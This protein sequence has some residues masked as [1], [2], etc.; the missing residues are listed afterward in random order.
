LAEPEDTTPIAAP[1]TKDP[2][3]LFPDLQTATET[4]AVTEADPLT[5]QVSTAP[6][7]S[8]GI[9]TEGPVTIATIIIDADAP[10]T[11]IACVIPTVVGYSIG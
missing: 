1:L 5:A 6:V 7:I 8:E 4:E 3:G 2:E 10:I 11:I 9:G